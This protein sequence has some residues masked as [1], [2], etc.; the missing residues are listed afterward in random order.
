MKLR[1]TSVSKGLNTNYNSTL[2]QDK[3][4]SFDKSSFN[5]NNYNTAQ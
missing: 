4:V 3:H 5:Y 2:S 1:D